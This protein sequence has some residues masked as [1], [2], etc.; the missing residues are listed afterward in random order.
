LSR[1]KIKHTGN[2]LKK[3]SLGRN[4]KV[5]NSKIM[6]IR[7]APIV[8]ALLLCNASSLS[9]QV[10]LTVNESIPN[11]IV[12]TS[13]GNVPSSLASYTFY[14]GIDLLNLFSSDASSLYGS[15]SSTL[16]TGDS[17]SGPI[18]DGY[19]GDFVTDGGLNGALD[20]TLFDYETSSQ[21]DAPPETFTPNPGGE[22]AFNLGG[23]ITIPVPGIELTGSGGNVFAG[24]SGSPGGPTFIG[25]YEILGVPEPS[26]YALML[27]GLTLLGFCL[28]R[29]RA[30]LS[31]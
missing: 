5:N 9:A 28:R 4:V 16:T 15:A 2:G 14:D 21:A 25:T 18:L 1:E 26:T 7:Y 29:K 23:T 24:Y 6:N 13:T 19:A 20:L 30:L 12:I 8:L 10:L 31:N 3:A 11:E 27:G 22:P 17:N